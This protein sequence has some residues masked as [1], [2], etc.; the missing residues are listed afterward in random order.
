[1]KNILTKKLNHKTLSSYLAR[2]FPWRGSAEDSI[3]DD[4]IPQEIRR[5]DV[6]PTLL[7]VFD[8][9]RG[10][11]Q[12]SLCPGW[13]PKTILSSIVVHL[14]ISNKTLFF[15]NYLSNKLPAVIKK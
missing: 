1:M 4:G 8:L 13:N 3:I 11:Q 7:P 5:G 10:F 14:N 12:S 2:I 9:H 6:S 15:I